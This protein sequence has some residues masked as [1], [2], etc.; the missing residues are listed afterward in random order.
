MKKSIVPSTVVTDATIGID[1]GD[2]KH[3]LCVLDLD[4]RIVVTLKFSPSY[5]D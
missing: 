2:L 1:L 5:P 3:A 4:G